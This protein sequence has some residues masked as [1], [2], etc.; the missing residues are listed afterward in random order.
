MCTRRPLGGQGATACG[1]F[2]SLS[3][4]PHQPSGGYLVNAVTTSW[5]RKILI[6]INERQGKGEIFK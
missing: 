1:K 5:P 6:L 2:T 4:R 3:L